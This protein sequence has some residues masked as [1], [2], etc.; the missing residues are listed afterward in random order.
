MGS[1]VKKDCDM[2]SDLSAHSLN[3]GQFEQALAILERERQAHTPSPRQE[4][5]AR[6]LNVLIYG[7]G[8]APVLIAFRFLV[9]VKLSEVVASAVA[10]ALLAIVLVVPV[11][12]TI[13][14]LMNLP[15]FFQLRRQWKLMRR[16]GLLDALRAPWKE[17]RRKRRLRNVLDLGVTVLALPMAVLSLVFFLIIELSTGVGKRSFGALSLFT[18]ALVIVAIIGTFFMRRR[19]ERLQL[20][21]RL[22]S[23]LEGYKEALLKPDEYTPP[24]ITP[25]TYEKIAEIE[26]AQIS[27][28]RAE[29][30]LSDL[31]E[32]GASYFVQKSRAVREHEDRLDFPTRLRVQDQIDA[33][34]AAPR[35]PGVAE[36][37]TAGT[38]HLRVPGTAVMI[39][40]TVDD[41]ARLIRVLA[42]ESTSGDATSSSEA[43]G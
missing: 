20:V 8:L 34:T 3:P 38:L 17:E 15:Y 4:T 37:P 7:F 31:D 27:R 10:A 21:S 23:A 28:Q 18:F 6:V 43:M 36:D 25:E 35:P 1:L 2:G 30:I 9:D 24:G 32:A 41:R 19:K 39:G 11:G 16:L 33:L 5:T 26:R 22:H 40:F 13:L 29:S 14:F 42:L 12:I